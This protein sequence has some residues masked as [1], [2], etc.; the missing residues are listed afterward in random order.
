MSD[1]QAWILKLGN[2]PSENAI[3]RLLKAEGVT[4]VPG[5]ASQCVVA[6]FIKAKTGS[7]VA[8]SHTT[9]V[10]EDWREP[11]IPTPLLVSN[12]ITKFDTHTYPDLETK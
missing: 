4:G 10:P 12:F 11:N 6:E 2:M 5:F 9:C 8:I 1:V 7:G 3:A